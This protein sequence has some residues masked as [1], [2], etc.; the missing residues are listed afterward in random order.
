[1]EWN[2]QFYALF[3]RAL[4]VAAPHEFSAMVEQII[5][6]P[7]QP[8]GD[9]A[10]ALLHADVLYFNDATWPPERSVELRARM[11]SRTM[12]LLRWSYNY[13]PG[14]LSI[15]FD[16]GR[17]V[18]KILLNTHD[19]FQGTRS[20]L[21]PAVADRLDPLLEPMRSLQSGGPTEFLANSS[22]SVSPKPMNSIS[23]SKWR[24]RLPTKATPTL[25]R[26]STGPN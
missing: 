21:V 19:P 12:S 3:A 16:T 15:D 26:Q 8:F 20:Y 5:K 23:A 1:M 11:A 6:L 4:M 17:V 24:R 13:S 14:P 7:D 18:A 22:R 2:A 25:Q 10:E 9:T